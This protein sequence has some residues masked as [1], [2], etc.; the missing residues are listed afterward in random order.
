MIGL[1]ETPFE[2]KLPDRRQVFIAIYLG[3]AAAASAACSSDSPGAAGG[4][5]PACNTLTD[6][7]PSVKVTVAVGVSPIATGGAIA[8]GTYELSGMTEYP[9]SGASPPASS[10]TF[11]SVFEIKGNTIQNAAKLNGV[12]TRYTSTFTI[13]GV[14]ISI[15]DS[16]PVLHSETHA[17]S[18]VANEIRF[19]DT[20]SAF[21]LEQR[22]T[23][24]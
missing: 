24:R 4:A 15:R 7:G 14:T 10:D 13:S 17:F 9:G 1:M 11:S 20:S 19:Y 8:D 23:L 12:E 16:C 3:L 5:T 6:D 22:Y 18:Y 2:L 21:T